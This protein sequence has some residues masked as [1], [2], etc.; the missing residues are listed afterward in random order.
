[1]SVVTSRALASEIETA[2]AATFN[3][4]A[5]RTSAS[6]AASAA[7]ASPF[8]ALLDQM[9][10]SE[11][12]KLPSSPRRGTA[13]SKT[14]TAHATRA[15][16]K[17][18][19]ERKQAA[20]GPTAPV[21]KADLVAPDPA[22][23]RTQSPWLAGGLKPPLAVPSGYPI[24]ET[25]DTG[26]DGEA[27]RIAV[28]ASGDA[29]PVRATERVTASGGAAEI[30]PAW[31]ASRAPR[32]GSDFPLNPHQALELAAA[33]AH[34]DSPPADGQQ[35]SSPVPEAIGASATQPEPAPG[36]GPSITALAEQALQT[37]RP[38]AIAGAAVSATRAAGA[39]AGRGEPVAAVALSRMS[40]AAPTAGTSPATGALSTAAGWK[41]VTPDG[42]TQQNQSPQPGAADPVAAAQMAYAIGVQ[43]TDS[44][45]AAF[46]RLVAGSGRQSSEADRAN[47]NGSDLAA[48]NANASDGSGQPAS[49]AVA[50]QGALAFQAVLV[51]ATASD[52]QLAYR[53]PLAAGDSSAQRPLPAASGGLS[54]GRSDSSSTRVQAPG[55]V[56]AAQP[57]QAGATQTGPVAHGLSMVAP[58]SASA[59]AVAAPEGTNLEQPAATP[60]P[61]LSAESA[62]EPASAAKPAAGGAAREIQL[63]LRDADARVNVRL[64]ER[65]G[66]VQVDVRTS[67]N[68][69]AG[70]LRDDLPA[71]T[72]RLEQT[73]LRAET[74]HDAPAAA[75]ARIRMAEPAASA[76]FQSSQNQS[77]QEGG[78]RDP[79][80]GQPQEKRQNQRQ[81]E[82][83]EFSWLYTSLQ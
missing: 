45:T 52:P 62:A 66:S 82:S 41:P 19:L 69:L 21:P 28:G 83:K 26:G 37:P 22:H 33:S 42:N 70:A 68:H 75:A 31:A 38:P 24:S 12:G 77:R 10:D 47:N 20:A 76:G 72:A 71:L 7:Q 73:G 46:A 67:D 57:D 50:Q 65:A 53:K 63:E 4:P 1:M 78:G 32:L 8:P 14:A 36:P 64:V 43:G 35:P 44:A 74:W 56:V 6:A 48:D 40:P 34:T 2:F 5:S 18:S 58:A 25:S 39:H 51:P 60:A 61:D 27:G 80:D 29:A 54:S 23:A 3:T 79:R 15:P 13:G 55:L 11:A 81:P 17:D 16:K 9:V 30:G 59:L 49:D